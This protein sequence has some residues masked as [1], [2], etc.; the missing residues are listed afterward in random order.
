LPAFA[1]DTPA[2]AAAGL[3]L[4]RMPKAITPPLIDVFFAAII[5]GLMPLADVSLRHCRQLAI[6]FD[7]FAIFFSLRHADAITLF[8]A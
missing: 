5:A 8:H 7:V 1:A 2:D 4:R 3:L 6:I